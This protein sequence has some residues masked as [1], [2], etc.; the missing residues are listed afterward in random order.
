MRWEGEE[1]GIWGRGRR[2]LSNILSFFSAISEVWSRWQGRGRRGRRKK[3]STEKKQEVEVEEWRRRSMSIVC[4]AREIRKSLP[5]KGNKCR[6]ISF[7]SEK[8]REARGDNQIK[9]HLLRLDIDPQTN[10]RNGN[11]FAIK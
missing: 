1:G 2:G 3:R 7:V 9:T 11:D 4:T 5:L 10:Q 8:D 6:S